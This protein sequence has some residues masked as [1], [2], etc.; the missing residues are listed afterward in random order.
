[1][2]VMH[3][4]VVTLEDVRVR[5][6]SLSALDL[7]VM[8]RVENPNLIG[9]TLRQLPFTVMCSSGN[10]DQEIAS[11][12]TGRIQ[13]PARG[14]TV[15][16]IPVTSRNAAILAALATFVTRGSVQVTI[17]GTATIDALLFGWSIPFTKTLPVTMA[18]VADAVAGKEP[19]K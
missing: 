13:I 16:R 3:D 4:P 18:Q 19:L 17:K 12:N 15:L 7:D 5:K 8:I 1:M 9:I 11:G 14:S 10:R 2:P 6:I